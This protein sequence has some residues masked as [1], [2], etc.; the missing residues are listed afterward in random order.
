MSTSTGISSLHD[1]EIEFELREAFREPPPADFKPSLRL[2]LAFLTL[3]VITMAVALDGTSLSVALPIISEK[4]KGTAIEA[5]WSGTS[6]L[7][8][9]TIFQPS[10]ASFSHIFG[11]KP[12]IM[13]ALL[14]FLVGAIIAAVANG[15]ATLLVGR[16]IQGIGGGGLIALTEIVVTDL[17]PLR[18]RGKWFGI[19]SGMWSLGS[20]TGPVIGGAFAQNVSWRWIFYINLPIIGVAFVFVPLFLKLNFK[21]T[22]LTSQLRRVDWLGSVLFIGSTTSFLI[23]IT[24][25]GVTYAWSSWRTLV[26]LLIGLAGLTFFII[27]EEFITTEPLIPLTVFKNRTAAV[28]YLG[29]TIHGMILWCLLYYLPLYYEAVKGYTPILSGVSLFP[30]TFTVAPAAVIVGV[31]VSATGRYRWAVWSGWVL[32]TLGTGLLYLLDVTTSPRAWIPL[33]F[34]SGLGTGMLFAGMAFAIQ[35]S[36]S[37][38][39]LAFA[40]AMF[41]FFR[42]FGQ[43]L[44]VAVGGSVFQNQIKTRLERYPALASNA[45]SYSR[46]AAALVQVIKDFPREGADAKGELVQA[47]ADALK[48]VW[49]TMAGL[50]AVAMVASVW[51]V[52]LDMDRPLETEQG[53]WERR[54]ERRES[55]GERKVSAV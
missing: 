43:A 54:R 13:V 2:Y 33:N 19:I 34:V 35:A 5:F 53:F 40:V 47:Y 12:V 6:F 21:P 37:N 18:L 7:L 9:S 23:P 52:G 15:F 42:A 50:A 46:D 17:V 30:Q 1:E 32:T 3:A 20:V 10:F 39:D 24:W 45:E 25:G 8:C 28:S 31:L 26:P 29:T 41:S 4:L 55:V 27:Y 38:K 51:T 22:N 36:A 11:R 16:S 44:G 48:V 14:L 49:G